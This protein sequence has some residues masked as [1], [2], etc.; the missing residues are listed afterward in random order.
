[1]L[2]N[3]Q[4]RCEIF[5]E[6]DLYIGIC[7]ELNVS[8]FGETI[9]SAKQ[10]LQEALLA[11]LEECE[12]MNTLEIVLEEAGFIQENNAWITRKPV[13]SELMALA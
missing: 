2:Q 3:I 5:R 7:P 10:S 12:A 8:S 1:M 4:V 11:F 6:D 9:E 13:L